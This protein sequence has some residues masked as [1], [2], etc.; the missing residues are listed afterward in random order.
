VIERLLK[1]QWW[2]FEDN[3]IKANIEL[4]QGKFS[5]DKLARLED[6]CI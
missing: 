4:F 2:H 3:L 5:K 6:I 1:I